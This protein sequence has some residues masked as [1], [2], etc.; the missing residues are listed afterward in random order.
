MNHDVGA[1]SKFTNVIG[2]TFGKN[3]TYETR[4]AEAVATKAS[5]EYLEDTKK[6]VE[7]RK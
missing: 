6:Q 5:T 3:V 1:G 7:P 2:E 4:A